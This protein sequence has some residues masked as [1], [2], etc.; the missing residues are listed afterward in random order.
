MPSSNKALI[1]RWFDEVWNQG[2]ISTIDEILAPHA[3]VHGLGPVADGPAGFKPFFAA[4]RESFPDIN[5]QVESMVEEGDLVAAHWRGTGTH[6]GGSLGIP[7]TN[8]AVTFEG[9]VFIRF[10]NG[11]FVE[12]WNIFTQLQM[13]QQ[14]GVTNLPPAQ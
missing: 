8:R 9:M 4:Y 10:E 12:G 13:L 7:A 3:K 1:Q 14:L 11:Q 2:R 6:R 5:I